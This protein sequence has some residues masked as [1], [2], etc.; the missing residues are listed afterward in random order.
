[1]PDSE[2][3]Q[4]ADLQSAP[5]GK[6]A[7]L[8]GT[9]VGGASLA[10]F[11]I[12]VGF[13][14][15]LEAF[16]IFFPSESSGGRS[17]LDVYY[18]GKEVTFHLPYEGFGWLPLLPSPWIEVICVVMGISAISL[19][20]GFRHR[21]SAVITFLAWGYLYA[22]EST[23]T[24]WMSYYYLE[25]I[26]L[27]LLMWMPT[28]ERF[29]VDAARRKNPGP[30]LIPYWPV[31]LLRAQLVITYFYAGLAKV[32]RDWLFEGVPVRIYLEKPWVAERLKALL[33][34]SFG[35]DIDRWVHS[36]GLIYFLS[37]SGAFF[38]LSVGF[39]LLFRRTR[40]LGMALMFLFHTFN[41]FV[42]FTDI[43][44][45]P[46]L[47]V[48]T[49]TIFLEPDWPERFGRWLTKPRIPRPDWRWLTTGAVIV[50]VVGAFLGW[51][52]SP[53]RK[54]T[55][56]SA[57]IAL[58]RWTALLVIGWVI[59]QALIPL[60]SRLMAGDERVT[61][62]G[63]SW[64]WRLKTEVYQSVPCVITVKDAEL[65]SGHETQAG[66]IDWGHWRGERVLY[67]IADPAKLDWS[68]QPE[69]VVLL[70]PLS[71]DRILY[72]TLAAGVTNRSEA[73]VKKRISELWNTFYGR[74]PDSI[75][76]TVP[77]AKLLDGYEK[78]M[79]STG[80]RFGSPAEV[81]ATLNQ[82]N[83]RFGDGKMLPL[84]RRL[85]PFPLTQSTAISGSWMLIEDR[86]L[87]H[88][89][90]NPIPRINPSL[91]HS[92][93]SGVTAFD[94]QQSFATPMV[95]LMETPGMDTRDLLPKF[96]VSD[97][98]EEQGKPAGI[99]WNLLRDAGMSKSMHVGMQPFLLRRYA[100]RVAGEWQ[101]EYGRQ[102]EVNAVATLTVNGHPV[103][104]LVDPHADLASV[105]TAWFGH[106][107]WITATVLPRPEPPKAP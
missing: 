52:A 4:S 2:L 55:S 44:W 6:V 60:R 27:F 28:A 93:N 68:T 15:L 105:G 16:S 5:S 21:V 30:G 24:Y 33:P 84:I 57:T 40:T 29:S 98:A 8:L 91:W 73:A 22:V 106:N 10:I 87:L 100:R 59:A 61:F 65:Q 20:I 94:A 69:L 37:W 81:F 50:P 76:Q 41:H 101:A 23:R 11:R 103:Q 78:A 19:M 80:M 32:N 46:L 18:T 102:P 86:K 56:S 90:P 31:L 54:Q 34:L 14:M 48:A 9:P 88:D 70:D 66:G 58:G 7:T 74:Q 25:A 3:G 38:D 83:G 104:N 62:E 71:G 99:R 26:S 43:V 92:G 36:Q 77:L 89:P 13:I 45:F 17:H 53:T 97:S 107:D 72:N 95:V 12:A 42:L 85:D 67:R 82:V 75:T 96:F 63:L 64:S 79:R 47:G 51:K 39:L 49:A 35:R 1:M